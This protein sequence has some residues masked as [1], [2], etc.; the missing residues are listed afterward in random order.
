MT[1]ESLHLRRTVEK[2]N[3]FRYVFSKFNS[4]GWADARSSLPIPFDLVT[5]LTDNDKEIP[6]WW[7]KFSW[8]GLRLK[9]NDVVVKWKRRRYEHIT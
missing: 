9:N 6:A 5:V 2:T 8:E 4:K 7:N 3:T 1:Q